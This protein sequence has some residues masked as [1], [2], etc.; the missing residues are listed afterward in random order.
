M[1]DIHGNIEGIRK[2]VLDEMKT[3]YDLQ[4]EPDVF[5][6][7][8]VL[9]TLCG[10]SAS[11]NREVALYVTRYGEIADVFIGRRMPSHLP[12]LRLRRQPAADEHD[13]LHP[14]PPQRHGAA[15]RCRSERAS[16]HAL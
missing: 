5:L 14:Y 4:L 8:E 11:F 9:S 2:S 7:Q 1:P 6:P 3:L 12:D 16:F 10:W 13:P 15:Q